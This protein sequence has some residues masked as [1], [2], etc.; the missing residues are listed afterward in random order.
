LFVLT[1]FFLVDEKLPGEKLFTC[2]ALIF[3]GLSASFLAVGVWYLRI[4]RDIRHI[5]S[6][7][8][9]IMGFM[10]V[11]DVGN[12]VC[13]LIFDEDLRAISTRNN[14]DIFAFAFLPIPFVAIVYKYVVAQTAFQTTLS[15]ILLAEAAGAAVF[16]ATSYVLVIPTIFIVKAIGR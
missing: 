8:L 13:R 7:A 16:V 2:L 5:L 1:N 3:Y 6:I 15:R 9:T 14:A 4:S 10:V 11:F 12:Y